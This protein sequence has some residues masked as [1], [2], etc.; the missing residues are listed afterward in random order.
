MRLRVASFNLESLDDDPARQPPFAERL[1]ALGPL[2]GRLDADVL[3]LQEVNAQRP[4]RHGPRLLTALDQLLAGTAYRGWPRAVSR[5]A[6]GHPL[7]IHNLVIVSR[8]PIVAERQHHHSRVPPL[9]W[10]LLT[11]GAA[12]VEVRFDRPLLAATLALPDGRPLHVFNV[13]LRA[14]LASPIPGQK[15]APFVWRTTAGWAEGFLLA[16]WKRI[17]QALELRLALDELLDQDPAARL[18]VAGDFNAD[19]AETPLRLV[20]ADLDDTGNPALSSRSLIALEGRVEGGAPYSVIHRGRRL[21][22]DH[23]LVSASLAAAHRATTIW[24]G[25]L[26]DEVHAPLAGVRP[27]LGFHAPLVVEL[28]LE[29]A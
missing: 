9:S 7:D 19:L 3:C 22:L 27:P 16:G 29:G 12:T 6:H 24:N 14:P 23:L 26:Q 13:H 17:A 11:D 2:L 1:A 25:E 20:R 10:S 8:F 18:L 5:T 15:L 4:E 21:L 28:E